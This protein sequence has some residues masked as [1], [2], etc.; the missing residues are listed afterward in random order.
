MLAEIQIAELAMKCGDTELAKKYITFGFEKSK[1]IY[2]QDSIGQK[3]LSKRVSN[4][5]ENHDASL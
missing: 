2:K 1:T 4:V 5:H 3:L